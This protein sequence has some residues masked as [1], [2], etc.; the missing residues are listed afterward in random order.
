[1]DKREYTVNDLIEKLNN[2]KR[3]EK[4]TGNENVIVFN[5]NGNPKNLTTVRINS[6]ANEILLYYVR[7]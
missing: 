1:M 5:E 6:N 2:L 7:G 3:M 4:L